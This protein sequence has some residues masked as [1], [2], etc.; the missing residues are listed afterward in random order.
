M[1]ACLRAG[2]R[3]DLVLSILVTLLLLVAVWQSAAGPG[4]TSNGYNSA[5][6]LSD[7]SIRMLAAAD[8]LLLQ[9]RNNLPFREP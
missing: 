3:A 8:V 2:F 6:R 9:H 5:T 4:G 7:D 1:Y